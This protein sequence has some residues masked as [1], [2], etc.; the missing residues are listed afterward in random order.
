[1]MKTSGSLRYSSH[2][3]AAQFVEQQIDRLSIQGLPAVNKFVSL[4]RSVSVIRFR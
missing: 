1:M 2:I 4:S 3:E